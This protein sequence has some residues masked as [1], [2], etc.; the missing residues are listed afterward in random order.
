[1]TN[2]EWLKTLSDEELSDWL[3]DLS[4]GKFYPA[5]FCIDFCSNARKTAHV[6]NAMPMAILTVNF[7]Y[8]TSLFNG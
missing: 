6:Q 7:L 3:T 4:N 2:K 1:M 5:D 8:R